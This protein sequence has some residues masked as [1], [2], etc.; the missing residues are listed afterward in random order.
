[1]RLTYTVAVESLKSTSSHL[2]LS[3]SR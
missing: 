3:N 1:V 2:S